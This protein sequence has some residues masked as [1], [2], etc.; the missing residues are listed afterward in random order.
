MSFQ[1]LGVIL[2]VT[3]DTSCDYTRSFQ[4]LCGRDGAANKIEGGRKSA[5]LGE[6]MGKME[7]AGTCWKFGALCR[8]FQLLPPPPPAANLCNQRRCCVVWCE[9]LLSSFSCCFLF[10]HI[11]RSTVKNIYVLVKMGGQTTVCVLTLGGEGEEYVPPPCPRS[12]T[13]YDDMMFHCFVECRLVFCAMWLNGSVVSTLGIR[14]RG[15]QFD[16]Q[17]VPLFHWVATLGKLFTHIASPVSQL[18]E[19]GVQKGVFGA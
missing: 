9:L 18:Q 6:F 2:R 1:T 14:A 11:K 17:V 15:P 16:Y 7:I 4:W 19:T 8:K 5:I 10:K 3:A 13:V 12:S